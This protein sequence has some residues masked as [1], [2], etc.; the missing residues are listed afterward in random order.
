DMATSTD[1]SG[2]F[3]VLPQAVGTWT[4]QPAKRDGGGNAVSALDAVYV[5]QALVGF[6]T[7]SPE[8]QIAC[9]VSGNGSVSVFDAVL[10]LQYLS[11]FISEFPVATTCGSDWAFI[12]MASGNGSALVP[13]LVATG[14]CQPGAALMT[15]VDSSLTQNFTAIR[16]GD[17]TG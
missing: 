8:Q 13:P 14:M 16:Y 4:V 6:R 10:I 3:S 9:D 7:L 15:L 1:A 2:A 12:P 17:C 11:G 5:L